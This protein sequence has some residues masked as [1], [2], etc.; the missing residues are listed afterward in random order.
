MKNF[1]QIIVG[2][3]LIPLLLVFSSCGSSGGGGSSSDDGDNHN[4]DSHPTAY[5]SANPTS[6]IAPLTVS[7]TGG[8]SGGDSP[9]SFYWDF[10]DGDNSSSQNPSHTYTNPGDHTA[11]FTVTDTDGDSDSDS[12]TISVGSLSMPVASVSANPTSG[13]EPLSVN[14]FGNVSGG[15]SPYSYNWAFGDGATSSSQNPSHTYSSGTYTAS[16]AVTDKNNNSDSASITI[17]VGADTNPV[18]NSVNANPSSGIAPL[19]VNF[20]CNASGG[21]PPLSFS[22]NFGDGGTSTTQNPSHIYSSSGTYTAS[23]TVKDSDLDSDTKSITINVQTDSVPSVSVSANPISGYIPLTVSFTCNASGG[24]PPLS[25]SWTFGD[26]SSS[27]SQNPSHTYNSAGN[28]TATCVVTDSDGDSGSASKTISA[29][30]NQCPFISLT[31]PS[32]GIKTTDST[33]TLKWSGSDPNGDS[34]SYVLYIDDDSNPFSAPLNTYSTTSSSYNPSLNVSGSACVTYYWGATV[35]DGKCSP[36]QSSVRSVVLCD[37]T[38]FLSVVADAFVGD[39]CPTCNHGSTT[40]LR[41]SYNDPT[42]GWNNTLTKFDP[43]PIPSG[44]TVVSAS[45]EFDI[46]NNFGASGLVARLIGADWSEGSVTFNDQPGV[47]SSP[48]ANG[49][50]GASIVAFNVTS[51]VQAWVNG[52]T[53]YGFQ[54]RAAN[55]S[56]LISFWSR[57]SSDDP[58]LWVEIKLNDP[59]N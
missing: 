43:S 21:N 5:A 17:S 19:T 29:S 16:L 23:C 42:N 49:S 48:S 1:K 27:S 9:L 14:F 22:W 31:S 51:H 46:Y 53:N 32:N 7:F 37:S 44:S 24:N 33:P 59:I 25:Y 11:T 26:G 58:M 54:I 39:D 20:T 45:L 55:T 41:V 34:L 3:M 47:Y 28:F 38:P 18:I 6:G 50:I 30:S 40:Y 52:T 2:L 12:I 56:P 15:V 35:S 10:G 13:L 36:V 8:V 57:E 4:Q